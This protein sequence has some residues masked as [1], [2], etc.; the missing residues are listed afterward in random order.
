V[1]SCIARGTCKASQ[2]MPTASSTFIQTPVAPSLLAG[3]WAFSKRQDMTP[4]VALRLVAHH[5]MS[6]AG[7]EAPDYE[8]GSER[9]GDFENWARRR[10]KAIDADGIS[11]VLIARVPPGFKQAFSE[12]ASSS[13]QSSPVALRTIV[14][15]VVISARI[16]PAEL[17]VPKI[18][19]PRSERV[20]TRFSKSEMAE[21]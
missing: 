19:E 6:R 18:S 9:R 12:Y 14:E 13:Q 20:A 2:A 16:E 7:F 11:P 4:S 17:Q 15:Q 1:C 21:L 5:Y 3:F 8:P 10:R